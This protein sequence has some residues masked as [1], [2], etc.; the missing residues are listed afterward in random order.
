[1]QKRGTGGIGAVFGPVMVVWFVAIAAA[2][3]PW[4]VRHPEILRAVNPH[5]RRALLRQ[6]HGS[7]ASSCS[8]RSSSASPAARRST[9]T[10]G[11]SARAPSGSPGTRCVFP[12]LLLNYFGQ[13]ALLLE[14]PEAAGQ[15][16]LRPGAGRRGSTRWSCWRPLATVIASQALISGAFSLTRQAVQ[17]G[18]LP[19]VTI[20]HTSGKT[21]GQIYIP[22]VNWLLMVACVALVLGFR[23]SSDAGRRLRHRG[24]RHDGH[25]LDPVLLRGARP[26]GLE[27]RCAPARC[28]RCSSA[29]DLSFFVAV[30]GQDRARRLVPA[31]G[32]GRRLHA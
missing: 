32:G 25:H 12:A 11:T 3:L 24:H 2:G 30:L 23:E 20:V 6:H 8:A 31:G 21:E 22:E 16:V 13:G 10:W 17:L 9:P 27:P 4:I 28:W 19:R 29:I 1:M 15:S 14:R 7:T 26:L 18:Y 5:L